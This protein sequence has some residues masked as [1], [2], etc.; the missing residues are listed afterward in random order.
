VVGTLDSIYTNIS[1]QNLPGQ[2]GEPFDLL[3]A[4]S[5]AAATIPQN[6]SGLSELVLDPLGLNV[7][8][9][10]STGSTAEK[11]EVTSGVFGVMASR[12]DGQAGAFAYLLFILLY[13]PCAATIAVIAREAGKPWAVFVAFWTTSVAYITATLFYQVARMGENPFQAMIT[14]GLV[15]LYAILLFIGLRSYANK[16]STG[17]LQ[18]A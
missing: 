3:L 10:E 14:I 17:D 12:F 5:A 4:L 7:A 13:F 16:H 1:E 2:A 6:L 9:I 15:T 8:D 18:T 11:L